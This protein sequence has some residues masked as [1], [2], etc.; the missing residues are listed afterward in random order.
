M[1]REEFINKIV[2]SIKNGTYRHIEI[3]KSLVDHL[4][5]AYKN[6]YTAE[7]ITKESVVVAR[8]GVRYT[9][10]SSVASKI[11]EQGLEASNMDL[12]LPW[13]TWDEACP[14]LINHKGRTYIRL[15][16]HASPFIRTRTVYKYKGKEIS[17]DELK[18]LGILRDGYWT[19][20]KPDTVFNIPLENVVSM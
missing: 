12:Q 11:I 13:G 17:E 14:Y 20:P 1:T 15:A 16:V 18:N 2:P 7:D 19:A 3:K 10:I 9:H 8:L 4:K 5:A 6:D